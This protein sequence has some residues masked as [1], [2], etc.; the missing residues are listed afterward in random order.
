MTRRPRSTSS[1]TPAASELLNPRARSTTWNCSTKPAPNPPNRPSTNSTRSTSSTPR[2]K[3]ATRCTIQPVRPRQ[4]PPPNASS[5]PDEH[6]ANPRHEPAETNTSRPRTPPDQTGMATI[7]P[8]ASPAPNRDDTTPAVG[9]QPR[10]AIRPPS[11]KGRLQL[12]CG[13][14]RFL[15]KTACPGCSTRERRGEL[16]KSRGNRGD[17][18]RTGIRRSRWWL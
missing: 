14:R 13:S 7:D 4:E 8:S 15:A 10:P 1:T 9:C 11:K 6:P 3:H 18:A 5:K 12:I 17:S 2:H 16:G